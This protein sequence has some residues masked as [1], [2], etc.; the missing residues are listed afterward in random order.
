MKKKILAI[1]VVSIFLL[2][3]FSSVSVVGNE[4]EEE[5][6]AVPKP[7]WSRIVW[8]ADIK[9]TVEDLGNYNFFSY[10]LFLVPFKPLEN[11]NFRVR[12]VLTSGEIAGFEVPCYYAPIGAALYIFFA[13]WD[14][15]EDNGDGT[16]YVEGKALRAT[17]ISV[18]DW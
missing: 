2:L 8:F 6:L 16:Y 5:N 14:V 7:I 11:E 3:G 12:M 9:G 1:C 17:V 18:F 4:A 15:F 10:Q 13:I